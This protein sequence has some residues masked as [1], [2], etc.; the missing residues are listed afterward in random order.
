[1][2]H[3]FTR[4]M[5]DGPYYAINY[6]GLYKNCPLKFEFPWGHKQLLLKGDDVCSKN[7]YAQN[8]VELPRFVAVSPGLIQRNQEDS[9]LLR[10]E[11]KLFH[12]RD[13]EIIL[14]FNEAK[15]CSL[16]AWSWPSRMISNVMGS[17]FAESGIPQTCDDDFNF[18]YLSPTHHESF[19]DTIVKSDLKNFELLMH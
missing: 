2:K 16:S 1:M 5:V 12:K 19:I 15:K 17:K 4:D 3:T 9:E 13:A 10:I 14:V 8:T 11:E 7:V 18:N 6:Y